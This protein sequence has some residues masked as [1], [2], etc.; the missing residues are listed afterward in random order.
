M[1]IY[2]I[3]NELP[4]EIPHLLRHSFHFPTNFGKP[5]RSSNIG[6]KASDLAPNNLEVSF[7]LLNFKQ[8]MKNKTH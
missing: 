8:G 2:K 6:P 1:E 3:S 5:G 7:G 4:N